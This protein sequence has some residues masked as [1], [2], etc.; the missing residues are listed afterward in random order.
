MLAPKLCRENYESAKV[1]ANLYQ[2][3]ELPYPIRYFLGENNKQLK[4]A[5][6]RNVFQYTSDFFIITIFTTLEGD[7]K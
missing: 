6:K 3:N 2:I 7:D 1:V 4:T 5:I